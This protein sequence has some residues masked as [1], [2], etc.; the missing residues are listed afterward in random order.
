MPSHA[1]AFST[2]FSVNLIPHYHC[3]SSWAFQHRSSPLPTNS[4]KNQSELLGS[5][6]QSTRRHNFA[7]STEVQI[8]WHNTFALYKGPSEQTHL[9]SFYICCLC[10]LMLVTIKQIYHISSHLSVECQSD[11]WRETWSGPQITLPFPASFSQQVNRSFQQ[12]INKG[13]TASCYW[14]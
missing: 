8:H 13:G 11:M 14:Q 7:S 12:A 9:V 5:H 1:L 2:Y 3:S 4:L 10:Y 6:Q